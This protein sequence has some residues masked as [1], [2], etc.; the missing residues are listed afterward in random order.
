VPRLYL[1]ERPPN[2]LR[3][4]VGT[5]CRAQSGA[6]SASV[7]VMRSAKQNV[8]DSSASLPGSGLLSPNRPS[9]VT[10]PTHENSTVDPFPGERTE[11]KGKFM[12]EG[13]VISATPVSTS[14]WI[15]LRFERGARFYRLHLEQDLWGAWCL[16][17][18]NGRRGARPGRWLTT[19][20][21]SYD[22]GLARIA[23][24]AT[25]RRQREY[26]LVATV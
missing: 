25:C 23:D 17:R 13:Q 24:A 7:S 4:R 12:R 14:L 5:M 1:V 18:V 10:R 6:R 20:P 22:Q 19:W 3:L 11:G 21:G 15:T 8:I 2:R 26:Q 9:G 16:T